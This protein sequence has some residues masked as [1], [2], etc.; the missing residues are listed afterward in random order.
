VGREAR[1]LEAAGCFAIVFEAI[2][3]AVAAELTALLSIP[4]IGIGAGAGTDG[5]VLVLHD[6]LGVYP[7]QAPRHSKQYADLHGQILSAIG[8]YAAEV[9]GGHFPSSENTFSIAPAELEA[10]RQ[11]L[12]DV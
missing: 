8:E 9:R 7:G 5:Q 2:P 10:F 6:M 11:Q 4:V 3:A 12:G 1:A